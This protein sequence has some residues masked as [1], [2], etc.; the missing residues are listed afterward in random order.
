MPRFRES[1]QES[2]YDGYDCY[3]VYIRLNPICSE[4][5]FGNLDMAL[6]MLV[7]TETGLTTTSAGAFVE[8]ISAASPYAQIP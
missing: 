8:P 7:Q 2:G 6:R 1:G 4:L 3:D 5:L